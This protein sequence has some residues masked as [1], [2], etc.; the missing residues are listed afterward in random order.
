MRIVSFNAAGTEIVCALGLR[1]SLVGRSHECDFP[2]DIDQLPRLSS[3]NID[4]TLSSA[5]IDLAVKALLAAR[6]PLYR[7]DREALAS[8]SPDVVIAQSQCEVCAVTGSDVEHSL[9][10]LSLGAKVVVLNPVCLSDIWNDIRA[11]ALAC[12]VPERGEVLIAELESRMRRVGDRVTASTA[13]HR[14]I[15]IVEWIEPLMSA[16]NWMPE[17]VTLA[18]AEEVFGVAG[19]H[20]PYRE[21]G[22]LLTADPDIVVVS[23]CGFDLARAKQELPPFVEHPD[24]TRLRAAADGQVFVADGNSFFHRPGPRIAEAV[25]ILGEIVAPLSVAPLYEGRGWE[26]V[27]ATTRGDR[28]GS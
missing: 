5:E 22:D 28:T 4:P 2:A 6:R 20:S 24:F 21:W 14:T 9:R 10:E 25:E 1:E 27:C 13:R 3:T 15:A 11:V 7:I 23:P 12:G 19:R 16:G 18:G 26:R 17:L 8:L